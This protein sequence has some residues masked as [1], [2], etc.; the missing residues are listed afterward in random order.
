[1]IADFSVVLSHYISGII[2][3]KYINPCVEFSHQLESAQ[4][5]RQTKL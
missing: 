2:T 5:K 3:E 1:M 4:H